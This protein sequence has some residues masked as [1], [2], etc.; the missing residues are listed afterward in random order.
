MTNFKFLQLYMDLQKDV[1]YDQLFDF[2]FAMVGY[3]KNDKSSF[4]NLALIE[5]PITKEQLQKIENKLVEL[6][7]KPALYFNEQGEVAKFVLENGYSKSNGDCWLFYDSEFVDNKNFELVKKVTTDQ[8]LKVFIET[9]DEC[10]QK[11]D[12]QNPYGELGEYL[13]VAKNAWYKHQNTN[14]LEYFVVYKNEV[15]VA[16][17]TLNN[18]QG[19]GYISNVGSLRSVR[20]E[21]FGK[22]ATLYCVVESRKKGN[23]VQCLTTEEGNYPHDFYKRIG[24]THKFTAL[25]FVKQ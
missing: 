12:P 19:I 15:P 5:E 22:L 8:D 10:Y 9:F 25:L 18:F 21:G 6:G 13:E 14:R 16:V 2:G 3:C 1:M 7:R 23:S 20:G 4:W 24:F 11:N 17:S